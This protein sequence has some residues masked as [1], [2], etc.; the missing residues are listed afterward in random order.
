MALQQIVDT[1]CHFVNFDYLPDKYTFCGNQ[2]GHVPALFLK[3]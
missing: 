1:H 2:S 3:L